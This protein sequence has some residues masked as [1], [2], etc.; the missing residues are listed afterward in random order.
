[1]NRQCYL[2]NLNLVTGSCSSYPATDRFGP[3][4]CSN[5]S[6][7]AE[8]LESQAH[9]LNYDT[10]ETD[11]KCINLCSA[12]GG[13]RR[14]VQRCSENAHPNSGFCLTHYNMGEDKRYKAER[15]CW[16]LAHGTTPMDVDEPEDDVS[17][18]NPFSYQTESSKPVQNYNSNSMQM[19]S[20]TNMSWTP[21]TQSIQTPTWMSDGNPKPVYQFGL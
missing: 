5:H 9:L 17:V 4:A 13:V 20:M 18:P 1:M 6:R 15:V 16:F 14:T 10:Y 12:S 3:L 7:N 11:G 8:L 21:N 2:R 19:P